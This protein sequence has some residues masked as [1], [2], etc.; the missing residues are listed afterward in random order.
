MAISIPVDLVALH[1]SLPEVP[2]MPVIPCKAMGA[3]PDG[4][5]FTSYHS[6]EDALAAW[7]ALGYKADEHHILVKAT[8]ETDAMIRVIPRHR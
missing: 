3:H 6:D 1:E 7:E 5:A 4:G 2:E 8:S